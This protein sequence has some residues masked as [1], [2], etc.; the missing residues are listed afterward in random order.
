[1]PDVPRVLGVPPLTSFAAAP[2]ALLVADAVRSI[3]GALQPRWGI[4]LDG[5][6]VIASSV[7]SLLGFGSLASALDSL[8]DLVGAGRISNQFS[9]V[10]FEYKQDASISDYPVEQGSFLSYNKVQSPYAV[11]ARVAAG[12]SESNRQALIDAAQAAANT[13]DLYDVVTPEAVYRSCNVDHID[14]KRS[15][16]RAGLI[17]MDI[18]LTEVRV[19]ATA[20]FSTTKQP[21]AA[22]QQGLGNVQPRDLTSQEATAASGSN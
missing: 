3:A 2:L 20:A 9:M 4:Y 17:V 8:G 5:E 7:S 15:S 14:Y 13:L 22:G 16:T 1:M 21:T 6:P 18:W 12:G 10:D 19:T 11:R